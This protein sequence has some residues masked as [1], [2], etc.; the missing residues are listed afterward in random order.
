MMPVINSIN[1]EGK[2]QSDE[3]TLVESATFDKMKEDPEAW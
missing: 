1:G 2:L 3:I